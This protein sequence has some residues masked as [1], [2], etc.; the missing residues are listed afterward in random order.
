MIKFKE[1]TRENF[2]AVIDMEVHDEQKGFME[3]NLFSLAELCF[4]KD[5]KTKVIYD[6]EMPIGFILYYFVDDNPDYVFLH[7]FMIDKKQQGHGY[8]KKALLASMDLFKEEFPSIECVELMHYPD[9]KIGEG[10]YEATGFKPTG[11]NR[12][13][14]PCIVDEGT[15]DPNRFVEIVRR[16]FY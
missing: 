3:G 11:E 9:N 1:V 7:R 12:P 16:K 6:D 4:E 5:F 10:L 14:G 8:G 15:D 2:R 13:S